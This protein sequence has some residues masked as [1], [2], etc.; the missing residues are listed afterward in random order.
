MRCIAVS[1]R[2]QFKHHS[3]GQ[4]SPEKRPTWTLVPQNPKFCLD[5][6][7]LYYTD[8]QVKMAQIKVKVRSTRRT[9][10]RSPAYALG[11]F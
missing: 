9:P 4:E 3:S 2:L 1:L 10:D 8:Y 5:L 7:N 11:Y 6:Q